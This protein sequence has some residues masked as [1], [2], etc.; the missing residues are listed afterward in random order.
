MGDRLMLT[1]FRVLRIQ[2]SFAVLAFVAMRLTHGPVDYLRG[3]VINIPMFLTTTSIVAALAIAVLSRTRFSNATVI[4]TS[5]LL[6]AITA[7][8]FA[9]VKIDPPQRFALFGVLIAIGLYIGFG[10]WCRQAVADKHAAHRD[11]LK[12]RQTGRSGSAGIKDAK[13]RIKGTEN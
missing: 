8:Q 12:R 10:T 5:S 1:I 3:H 7:S 6:A 9:R 13:R 4:A 2:F 11:L